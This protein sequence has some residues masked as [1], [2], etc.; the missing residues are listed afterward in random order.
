MAATSS[1]S[2]TLLVYLK[3][4]AHKDKVVAVKKQQVT[5][6]VSTPPVDNKANASL[7]KFLS[8]QLGIPKSACEIVKGHKSRNKTIILKNLNSKDISSRLEGLI[9]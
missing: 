4:K 2:C 1:E 9:D 3:P 8:K 6:A 5:I 7:I